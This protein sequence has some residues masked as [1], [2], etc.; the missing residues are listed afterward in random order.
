MQHRFSKCESL[1]VVP[2]GKTISRKVRIGKLF[3][4]EGNSYQFTPLLLGKHEGL[5]IY[6]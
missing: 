5:I 1:S 3:H 6:T 2:S 4:M